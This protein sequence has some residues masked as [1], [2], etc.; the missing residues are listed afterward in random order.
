VIRKGLL[1]AIAWVGCVC[2]GTTATGGEFQ[3]DSNTLFLAHY[4]TSLD[5]DYSQGPAKPGALDTA[6]LTSTGGYFGGGLVARVGAEALK[7]AGADMAAFT[8]IPK[9]SF[10]GVRYPSPGNLDLVNGTFECWYRPYF[11]VKRAKDMP[12]GW[13]TEYMLFT[14]TESAVSAMALGINQYGTNGAS[15]FYVVYKE[16]DSAGFDYGINWKPGA[17][18]HVAI[19]WDTT[20]TLGN[21]SL[22]LDGRLARKTPMTSLKKGFLKETGMY[23][24]F[25]IGSQL[26]P[27]SGNKFQFYKADGV[28]DEVRISN[29]VRYKEDFAIEGRPQPPTAGK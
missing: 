2:V 13:P 3:P 24:Y 20:G 10:D 12:E 1:S 29:I 17:W 22:F 15:F 19:T 6:C 8:L 21:L 26:W 28:I 7:E 4:N 25:C 23:P 16:G 14:Y 11:S 18:H 5:A 27:R 9:K